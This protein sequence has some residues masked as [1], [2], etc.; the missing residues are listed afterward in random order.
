MPTPGASTAVDDLAQIDR[1]VAIAATAAADAPLS[2]EA[3]ALRLDVECILIECSRDRGL[4]VFRDGLPGESLG[5]LAAAVARRLAP[6]IGGRYV[7][8]G[9]HRDGSEA[10][11][12]R[13]AAVIAAWDA[14]ASRE[15][16]VRRFRISRR[17]SY[18]ITTTEQKRR[19]RRA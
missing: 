5:A 3:A 13:D 1:P 14:G 7:P 8:K 15:E 2:D 11:A 19:Q 6:R 4:R 12:Q 10:R 9:L 18:T 16:I 17:L